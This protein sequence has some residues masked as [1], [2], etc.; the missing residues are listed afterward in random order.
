VREVKKALRSIL[1][2]YKLHADTELFEKAYGYIKEYHLG[3]I[4]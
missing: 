4:T 3:K 1:A 2:K